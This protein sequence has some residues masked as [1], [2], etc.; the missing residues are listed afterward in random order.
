MIQLRGFGA[1]DPWADTASDS[2]GSGDNWLSNAIGSF[3]SSG[4]G[5]SSSS[6]SSAGGDRAAAASYCG[7]KFGVTSPDFQP[8]VDYYA[9]HSSGDYVPKTPT[10]PSPGVTVTPGAGTHVTIPSPNKPPWYKTPVGIGL[11]AL[12]ALVGYKAYKNRQG[13]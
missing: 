10:V 12:G 13:A 2:S 5:S 1:T 11:I 9:T 8:C 7:Q 4:S 3:F 6:S